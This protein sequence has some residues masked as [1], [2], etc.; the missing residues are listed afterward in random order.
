MKTGKCWKAMATVTIQ[1][2]LFPPGPLKELMEQRIN[3][4]Y[5]KGNETLSQNDLFFT[6]ISALR[7]PFPA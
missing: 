1:A 4:R 5:V 2:G 3:N 6:L 7:L